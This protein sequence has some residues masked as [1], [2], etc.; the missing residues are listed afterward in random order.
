MSDLEPVLSLSEAAAHLH[1]TEAQLKRLSQGAAPKIG[2]L[3]QGRILVYPVSA[4]QAY[5]DTHTTQPAP[6]NPFGLT[7][8]SLKR[9]RRSA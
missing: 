8:A 9:V 3:K 4:V 2:S 5:I 6:P 1:I 7:D